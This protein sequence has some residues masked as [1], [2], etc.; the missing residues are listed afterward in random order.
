VWLHA[1]DLRVQ[2]DV[3]AD[4]AGIAEAELP[5]VL[6]RFCRVAGPRNRSSGDVGRGLST[7]HDIAPRHP[8]E[9]RLRNVTP[10]GLVA[11]LQLPWRGVACKARETDFFCTGLDQG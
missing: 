11:S 8:G 1:D 9:I 3:Q 7:A 5:K 10:S 4:G 2:L 6:A